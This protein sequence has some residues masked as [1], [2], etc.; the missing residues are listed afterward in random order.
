M[1]KQIVVIYKSVTGFTRQYA[2]WIG[3]ALDCPVLDF[4]AA[5]VQAVGESAV[6][7]FGGRLHA[8]RIDGLKQAKALF[9]QSKA[10]RL[11]VFAT[12]ATPSAAQETIAQVWN[13][14]FT[15][16]ELAHI[17]HFYM[18]SGLRYEK[19]SLG[20]RLMMKVF[21]AMIAGKKDKSNY[22]ASMGKS[23]GRSWDSSSREYIAPL[24]AWALKETANK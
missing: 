5:S 23:L 10:K 16:E 8:G 24:T 6:M 19:M 21:A 20:D 13:A 15:P 22:E 9:A 14:N 12:G 1:N 3:Q 7:I 18:Q 4:K 11:A 17:P 2:Q